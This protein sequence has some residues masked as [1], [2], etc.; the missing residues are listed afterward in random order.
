VKDK[1]DVVREA[2]EENRRLRLE[3]ANLRVQVESVKMSC[4]MEEASE[5]T[6]EASEKLQRQT[7]DRVGRML[8]SIKYRPPTH[9]LPPQL[10]TLGTSYFRAEDFEKAAVIL[11][12]LTEMQEN[13]AYRT[14]KN[15]LMLGVAWFRLDNPALAA[16]AFEQ[17][18]EEPER[19][20]NLSYQ[21]QARLWKA[22][23]SAREGKSMKT[24]F[25]LRELVDR[26]PHSIEAS[27]VNVSERRP[28]A[29]PAAKPAEAR[30]SHES[31]KSPSSSLDSVPGT[32]HT[33]GTEGHHD[34]SS[35]HPSH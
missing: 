29:A 31:S 25:W 23:I 8:A 18:L 11:T 33:G 26:H 34:T 24:Q 21:A 4:R 1:A 32:S 22:V 9:L 3:N 15:L 27:W 7:G 2:L 6:A 13:T 35:S 17:A 16:Q 12:L 19:A 5:K 30:P 20:E 28:A 10:Y 14:A